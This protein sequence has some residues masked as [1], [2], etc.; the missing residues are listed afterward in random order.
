MPT[1]GHHAISLRASHKP[2][3]PNRGFTLLVSLIAIMVLGGLTA[4][5][6]MRAV[7]NERLTTR[8]TTDLH[9]RLA[10]DALQDRLRGLIA[11][12]ML[13]E[14]PRRDRPA[15]NGTPFPMLQDGRAWQVS[16][17]DQ[18]GLVDLYMAPPALLRRVVPNSQTFLLQRQ[19]MLETGT[20]MPRLQ[21]TLARLGLS[22]DVVPIFTQATT[23]GQIR[24]ANSPIGLAR[25]LADLPLGLILEGQVREVRIVVRRAQP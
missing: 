15:L 25:Y 14:S 4:L 22:S 21:M 12:Q 5:V 20:R 17:Q 23:D 24:L 9:D 8:L 3:T 13:A 2:R 6:Q 7:A 18:Q 16:V 1:S 11:D 10:H 19:A